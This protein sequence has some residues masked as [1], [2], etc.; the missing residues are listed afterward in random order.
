MNT[1]EVWKILETIPDP[2]IPVINIIELGI[3]KDVI[4]NE[5][6]TIVK[7][8]PTY[9]GCPAMDQIEKDIVSN[10]RAAG[11]KEVVVEKIYSP[12][13]TTD[14]I[15]AEAKAKLMAYGISP[16]ET[17]S[18][19]KKALLMG[20]EPEVICPRCKSSNTVMVSQFGSTACKALYKCH[21]CLEPF[22]HFKCL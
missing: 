6:Q 10:L 14:F 2:E 22:D 19:N 11:I 18:A 4:Q 3:V 5:N 17:V 21:Q 15:T 16:P 20:H 7:I 13:W 12:A 9:S 1:N 8:T